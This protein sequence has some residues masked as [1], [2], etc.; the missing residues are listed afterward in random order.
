MFS[1]LHCHRSELRQNFSVGGHF[2]HVAHDENLWVIRHA[3]IG[4]QFNASATP[5]RQSQQSRERVD[6]H[7]RGP[8]E[9]M[10]FDFFTRHQPHAGGSNLCDS[11]SEA[12]F[13]STPL[14]LFSG[15]FASST[16]NSFQTV[17][18]TAEC[19]GA[20]YPRSPDARMPGHFPGIKSYAPAPQPPNLV[21]SDT[22][23]PHVV[24]G[25]RVATMCP[26][27][28][29]VRDCSL[30]TTKATLSVCAHGPQ[31]PYC[32]VT[33]L[34]HYTSAFN[35]GSG[36]VSGVWLR[37]QWYLLDNSVLSDVQNGP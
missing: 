28:N 37:P 21:D 23:Y 6:A 15:N 5:L 12:H 3:Q 22:Y 10:S 24:G 11:F 29:G 7:T 34:D 26:L 30:F 19:H 35:S 1:R 14:K 33:V 16:M 4:I 13:N 31:L 36:N 9:G 2:T 27:V 32:A 25:G 20:D 17:S 8:D 18:T